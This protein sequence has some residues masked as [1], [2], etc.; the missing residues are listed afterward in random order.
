MTMISFHYH[1][2]DRIHYRSQLENLAKEG[3]RKSFA[4]YPEAQA[5]SFNND[6]KIDIGEG[7]SKY[8]AHI[9]ETPH[10]LQLVKIV[11]RYKSIAPYI[12]RKVE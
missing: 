12:N 1:L 10:G 2:R 4:S 3:D 8:I 7:S 11:Y 5:L 6:I 9:T